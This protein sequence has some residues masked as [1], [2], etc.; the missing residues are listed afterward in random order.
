[1]SSAVCGKRVVG[2]AVGRPQMRFPERDCFLSGVPRRVSVA[3]VLP[4]PCA[5]GRTTRGLFSG[6]TFLTEGR[7]SPGEAKCWASP[8]G[9]LSQVA[10][11]LPG[12]VIINHS[13]G[14]KFEEAVRSH[15]D[16]RT[17]L[18]VT[19]CL[20]SELIPTFQKLSSRAE[21]RECTVS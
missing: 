7:K 15:S 8:R 11:Y 13:M 3:G 1:M 2:G 18:K 17:K 20:S 19:R 12:Y 21:F 5:G 9:G 16:S 14:V 6:S 4:T 10:P